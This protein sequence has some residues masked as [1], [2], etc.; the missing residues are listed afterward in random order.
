[1][2]GR[3]KALRIICTVCLIAALAP[4]LHGQVFEV[5]GGTSSLY[6]AQGGTIS[7]KGPSYDAS[8]GVGVIAG[9]FVGGGNFTKAVGQST[10][11]LGSDYIHFQLPTDI[12]D[13]SH[14][15]VALGAGMNTRMAGTN[16]FAFAGATSTSFSSPLFE[17]ARAENAAGILF[18]DRRLGKGLRASSKMIFSDQTTAIESL[19]WTPA[20]KLRFAFSGGV[21]ANQR[22]GAAS[23]D[24][25]RTWFAAKAAYISAGSQFHRVAVDAPLMSETDRENLLVTLKPSRF[26]SVSG[27]RQNFL[28]PTADATQSQVRSSVD[29]ASGNL[30]V[31]KSGLSASVF[32]SSYLNNS[33]VSTAYSADRVLF[34]RVRTTASYLESRPNNSIKTRT[35]L[36]NLSETLTPRLTVAEFV[37]RS[38]GQTTVSFGGSLLSNICTI[39]ADY[40]TYYIPE[41]NSNPFEQA[42]IIDLQLHLIHGLTLHGATFV[43]PDGKLRYTADA[44]AVAVRT[45]ETPGPTPENDFLRAGMGGNVLHGTVIDTQNHPVPGAAI[46]IDHLLVYTD[47][48]GVFIVRERKPRAHTLSII[49]SQFLDGFAYRVVSAPSTVVSSDKNDDSGAVVVVE[50][51]KVAAR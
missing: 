35:F 25:T 16:V 50:R 41:R 29:L 37:N 31:A 17:G 11:I 38:Q 15:L 44:Q 23:L 10:Y 20:E 28:S 27:G 36:T 21:G 45:S 19:E 51:I 4:R 5:S 8:L 33:N 49:N 30:L 7:A 46:M 40:Q 32:H 9:K 14:Y 12:F 3:R 22:Y 26:F 47:D 1:V 13:R 39:N 24:F 18:L 6:E 2:D 48:D 42:L 43:S 34:S